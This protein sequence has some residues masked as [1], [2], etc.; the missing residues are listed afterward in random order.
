MDAMEDF[1]KAPM[2]ICKL[3]VYRQIL[4]THIL[5]L[6]VELRELVKQMAELL[7]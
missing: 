1:Y 7:K 6:L 4:I 5:Q 2:L 3:K